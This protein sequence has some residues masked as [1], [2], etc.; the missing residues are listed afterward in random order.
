MGQK[1]TMSNSDLLTSPGA[2]RR[3]SNKDAR[4][5]LLD[6][7]QLMTSPRRKMDRQTL[8]LMIG[9]LGFVQ[10]DSIRTIERAHHMIL[11]A[12]LDGYKQDQL[13]KLAEKDRQLFENWTHDAALLPMQFYPYWKPR[14]KRCREPLLARW[15]DWRRAGFEARFEGVIQHIRDNGPVKARDLAPDRSKGGA[16]SA[17]WWNWHPDKSALEFL[18]RTGALAVTRREGFQKVYDLSERVVTKAHL[19]SE[20]TNEDL[21]DW[22]V[23]SAFE[24][25][26]FGSIADIAGFWASISSKEVK[27]WIDQQPKGRVVSVTIE[28][29]GT[30]K[31]RQVLALADRID[32]QLG[33][34]TAQTP[35]KRLRIINPFDPLIRDR[36]RLAQVF[37]F[38]YRIEVFVPEAKRQYGYYVCPILEGSRMIGR[39]DMRH[40][41]DEGGLKIANIWWE[42]GIKLTLARQSR[43]D[44]ELERQRQFIDA[45]AVIWSD[46]ARP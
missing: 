38:E 17:G 7:Y 6:R 26:G 42:P 33:S 5:W 3:I 30:A 24:R 1:N 25:L 37:G 12:R 14:F 44:A 4:L 46:A 19:E 31:P 28:G 34:A 18:W 39:I 45:N 27:D 8:A 43:L 35:P 10:L 41:R 15:R 29:F 22:A 13:W 16:Q 20:L 21:I 36:K 9:A 40:R 32:E 11:K 2:D 23:E